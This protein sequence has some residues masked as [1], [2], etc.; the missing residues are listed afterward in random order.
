MVFANTYKYDTLV[1]M[2]TAN[3]QGVSVFDQFVNDESGCWTE[4]GDGMVMWHSLTYTHTCSGAPA[5]CE[6]PSVCDVCGKQISAAL[7]HNYEGSY[8]ANDDGTH[9]AVCS[10]DPSH[11]ET[12]ACTYNRAVESEEYL[13]SEATVGAR[14]TYYYSCDCGNKGTETFES[15]NAELTFD[16]LVDYDASEG[17][18]A[19]SILGN[20]T[21]DKV[22]I[23]STELTLE[24]GGLLYD[25][26]TG[27]WTIVPCDE[28]GTIT[29]GV[30]F[31]N[32]KTT[33]SNVLAF[34]IYSGEFIYRFTNVHYQTMVINDGAE[35]K[36]ALDIDYTVSKYNYGFYS[37]GNNIEGIT[38]FAYTGFTTA[39]KSSNG[40]DA[41]F[42]GQ[43]NGRGFTIDMQTSSPGSYGLFGAFN[44]GGSTRP[45][46]QL[47]VRDFAIVNFKNNGAPVLA[48]Y[49]NSHNYWA[50]ANV[51][52][53]NIYVKH[54][55]T[56]LVGGG[57]IG[58]PWN[59]TMINVVVDF[60]DNTN[61]S[62]AGAE[63]GA[64]VV[65]AKAVKVPTGSYYDGGSVFGDLRWATPD[66]ITGAQSIVSIGKYPI[67]YQDTATN[68]NFYTNRILHTV[69]DD[70]SY[71]HTARHGG[72]S[73][74]K[75][76][77]EQYIGYAA[78]NRTK[79]DVPVLDSLKDSF[80][81][82]VSDAVNGANKTLNGFACKT[83]YNYFAL[84]AG[85]CP[86]CSVDLSDVGNLWDYVGC[87]NWRVC[88]LATYE[89]PT[90]TSVNAEFKFT[91]IYKYD[92]LADMKSSGNTFD[93]FVGEDGNGMWAVVDG[94]L[95]WVGNT[96]AA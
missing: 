68:A 1:D 47:Y 7:G 36:A 60:N 52:M 62:Y 54:E 63:Y 61:Y 20:A 95:T 14:A 77:G 21:L 69:Q 26:E 93:S 9:S 17:K 2:K 24:N 13:A 29:V 3:L 56:A 35:L 75:V 16:T 40:G 18:L 38:A 85:T 27:E 10:R 73:G 92:T 19:T 65:A 67:C 88:D 37:L 5:T 12:V 46:G 44:N 57:L 30:P 74:D 86:T 71:V 11:V 78:A 31:M 51:I 41:G 22:V 55:K 39:I 94:A 43:F 4:Y 90:N 72:Y 96:T 28:A 81:S 33:S 80:A 8:T 59:Y 83:C 25:E 64:D 58:N 53:Q 42:N 15:A 45:S 34:T 79:G 89:N 6:E 32:N 91:N 23:G 87:Y 76:T 48:K 84:E 50:T 49:T 82:L 66:T 70:G